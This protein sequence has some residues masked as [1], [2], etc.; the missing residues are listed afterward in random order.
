MSE[1]PLD[2]DLPSISG[3][4]PG[5]EADPT[6]GLP[7]VKGYRVLDKLGQGGMGTV[8][9]AVQLSTQREVAL[10]LLP[11]GAF[12]SE[13]TR[14]R[15]EREIELSARLEHP[16]IARVYESGLHQ[17]VYCYAMELVD[18]VH[19]DE[20]AE[21]HRLS[22]RERLELVRK[23]CEAVQHAHQRGV[24]HRDLKPSNILVTK[25]GAPHVLD[26]GLAK[27]FLEPD[28]DVTVSVDGEVAGTPAYMSP[29][30]A[31]GKTD[32]I[33]TRSDV[34]SLGVILFRL[35]T[36]AFPHDLSGT[37]FE[38]LRRI[39]EE[40]IK[41]P[42]AVTKRVDKELESLL[43]KALDHAP[44]QRYASAGDLAQD[45]GN[46]LDGEPLLAKAPTTR[47]F[48]RK[49][50]RKHRIPVTVACLVVG[51]IVAI[52]VLDYIRV[53]E[54]R[55]ETMREGQRAKAA[56]DYL[57]EILLAVDPSAGL[58]RQVT[59]RE[60]FDRAAKEVGERFSG[61][62][63]LEAAVR[64]ILGAGYMALGQYADA[65]EHFSRALEIY[66]CQPGKDKRAARRSMNSLA[67]SQGIQGK[68]AEAELLD[69]QVLEILRGVLAKD[70]PDAL[71]VMNNLALTMGAQGKC[72]EAEQ[73]LR[74]VVETRQRVLGRENLD[75]LLSL[76]N[77]AVLLSTQ[78][79]YR[80]AERLHAEVL[81][82]FQRALPKNHLNTLAS[83]GN[84]ANCLWFQGKYADAQK[85]HKE[86]LNACQEVLG[87][88]H[89]D[90]LA[91]MNDLANSLWAGREY[92]EAEQSHRQVLEVRRLVLG[93][94][95]PDTL[96]SM[97]NLGCALRGQGKFAEALQLQMQVV[98]LHR[99]VLGKDHRRTLAAMNNLAVL[100]YGEGKNAE[101]ESLHRET[102]E[103][104]QR[105]LGVDHP[106]TVASMCNLT[107]LLHAQGRDEEVATILKKG[108]AMLGRLGGTP[109]TEAMGN[110][111]VALGDGTAATPGLPW[112]SPAEVEPGAESLP[113]LVKS[114]EGAVEARPAYDQPWKP[115]KV[116]DRLAEGADVRTGSRARCL[117]EMTSSSVQVEPLTVVRIGGLRRDGN[118]IPRILLKEGALWSFDKKEASKNG[119]EGYARVSVFPPFASSFG[120]GVECLKRPGV[121]PTG[122]RGLLLPENAGDG[123]PPFGQFLA[124]E[125]QSMILDRYNGPP[126]E[127]TLTS[128]ATLSVRG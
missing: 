115:V 35:V 78:G 48:L 121:V 61:N 30:Q 118:K 41:R 84:L 16:H 110:I 56:T 51:F 113:I 77:L 63:D 34:Y 120:L 33:D 43:L 89:P 128:E 3:P 50:L 90:T 99:R 44:S 57:Q 114:V 82:A 107:V 37:R 86:V 124:R 25:D 87:K 126:D 12:S 67:L 100:M 70:H 119:L 65:E 92:V 68:Y 5:E 17:G 109:R 85:L 49:R 28:L 19:L 36:G 38:V 123:T 40:E 31:A 10:K 101:A 62:P 116:G 108:K 47:Y 23:V 53:T 54:A 32:Q 52:V 6:H 117:L 127:A 42:R 80:D 122:G 13:R 46:Y 21:V 71:S 29:E 59:M 45:I 14:V 4:D 76:H 103:T 75:T 27:A 39:A 66:R 60:V 112:Q 94:E 72:A 106:E 125:F 81:G 102:L 79:K 7:Q 20:Y 105:V 58:G 104:Q 111:I 9:R 26:F 95:H 1:P 96:A 69:R 18:G 24:I 55:Q 11:S 2:N 73:L 97:N 22:R 64:D 88:E 91:S 93:A 83:M 74:H 8:W 98:E 15:F